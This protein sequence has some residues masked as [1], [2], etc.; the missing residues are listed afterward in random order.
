TNERVHDLL[1]GGFARSPLFTGVIQGTGPRYCPSI[2]D[3]VARFAARDS[4]QLFLEPEGLENDRIYINGFSS[5]LPADVQDA[6]LRAIPALEHCEVLRYGYAVEYDAIEARSLHPTLESRIVPG[7]FVAGQTCGTSGYEEAAAQGLVAGANAALALLGREPFLPDRASSYLGVLVDDLT[8]LDLVEPYRLFTSRAEFRLHLRH[9]NAEERLT[10]HGWKLGMVSQSQWLQFQAS[11]RER[12]RLASRLETVKL[13]VAELR[14]F[15]SDRGESIPTQSVRAIEVAK[16]SNVELADLLLAFPEQLD[17]SL[18]RLGILAVESS[19]R[20]E[21]FFQR[22]HRDLE[23]IQKWATRCFP[24]EMD[25]MSATGIS[26][27]A[28]EALSRAKPLT[29]GQAAKLPGVRQGDLSVLLLFV[30]GSN[31]N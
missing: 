30:S 3:K 1:R 12:E 8:G 25:W 5:S 15:L 13:S 21:G 9:D 19:L 26:M 29:V 7:L 4:H 17:H 22:E 2:E 14:P 11:K 28:R 16:R 24:P 18:D 23:R 10:E 27:E 6:A 31:G 20:Y